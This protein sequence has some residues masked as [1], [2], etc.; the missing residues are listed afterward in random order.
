MFASFTQTYGNRP[1]LLDIYF[2]DSRL[3]EFKN[4]LDLNIYS[5]HN[6][7]PYIIEKFKKLNTVKNTELLVF[8]DPNINYTD[9][10]KIL[11]EK[12]KEHDCKFLFF[13]QDDTFSNDNKNIDF[14]E[15][16]QYI[17]QHKVFCLNLAKI[18]K[19]SYKPSSIHKN[20]FNVF[21][22]NT[23]DLTNIGY[24]GFDDTSYIC[25]TNLLDVIYDEIYINKH[26][27]WSAET[28]LSTKFATIS[29]PRFLTDKALFIN[30]NIMGKTIHGKNEYLAKLRKRGLL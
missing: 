17:K 6:A 30:Y 18:G 24:W 14:D 1:L 8:N 5:F 28:Y 13:S 16:I 9:T 29:M 11:K 7:S 10:I 25:T 23:L 3:I 15:L 20:T 12:L 22:Y 21:E 4:K 26:D 19:E 2:R 27:V